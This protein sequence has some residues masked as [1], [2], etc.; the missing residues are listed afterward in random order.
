MGCLEH[1]EDNTAKMLASVPRRLRGLGLR[2][3][4]RSREAAFL[5]S[6]MDAL[7]ILDTKL[8]ALA[9]NI[10]A[11]VSRRALPGDWSLSELQSAYEDVV[12]KGGD[13]IP[14]WET[15]HKGFFFST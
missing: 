11:C 8:P 6:W 13:Q 3:A 15:I 4:F 14:A 7:P 10:S 2:S 5:A 12:S 9:R 1:I